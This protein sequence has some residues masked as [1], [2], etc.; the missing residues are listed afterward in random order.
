MDDV[1][2]TELFSAYLDGELTANEQVRVEQILAIS[3]EARQLLEELRA[4]G[5]TLQGVPQE[6][7]DEDLSLRV[8]EVA[9]QRMLLPDR[10]S[11]DA[12]NKPSAG[13]AA[14]FLNL[15][16]ADS[17]HGP[18]IPWREISWR[19]MFSKRALIWS[20]VV[21]ATAI[22]IS[23][24]SPPPPKPNHDLAKL[25]KEPAA[26]APAAFG[27]NKSSTSDGSWAAPA[28][29][30]RKPRTDDLLAKGE[31]RKA[32]DAEDR[33]AKTEVDGLRRN[34]KEK[35]AVPSGES[36]DES[37]AEAK[38]AQ[39]TV[40]SPP[41][42][43]MSKAPAKAEPLAMEAHGPA[44]AGKH[45]PKD[46][47]IADNSA[48][49]SKHGSKDANTADLGVAKS[50][51]TAQ[52]MNGTGFFSANGNS[53]S[54]GA[55][56]ASNFQGGQA[57]PNRFAGRKAPAATVVRINIS[58]LANQNRVF[59]N[60]L[61]YQGLG[62]DQNQQQAVSQFENGKRG[63]DRNLQQQL[64][65]GLM[66]KPA[67]TSKKQ[68]IQSNFAANSRPVTYE[69]DASPEQ[70]AILIKQLGE[71]PDSFSISEIEVAASASQTMNSSARNDKYQANKS[72]DGIGGGTLANRPDS[73][74]QAKSDAAG[75]ATV[76]RE[77]N[78]QSQAASPT[79]ATKQHVVFVLRVVDRVVPAAGRA[80][81]LP[82]ATAPAKQ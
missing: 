38:P 31:I 57:M 43:V 66:Q 81:Q 61:A 77:E 73:Q 51:E 13:R 12:G 32:A 21:V 54:T 45:V 63:G 25:D 27:E 70:L 9:E 59:E 16:E 37:F 75:G 44:S 69:F 55:V 4:L 42:V 80:S 40:P 34:E 24:T 74:R 47:D 48:L 62:I 1:P 7:L 39:A 8:M 65:E 78:A 5:S 36:S 82:A 41:A 79:T 46:A 26:T 17:T 2:D 49:R 72:N 6:K 53:T 50:S 11:N 14:E 35:K 19:G 10:L 68:E 22:I 58:A 64:P 3:P 67:E 33:K 76:A 18:G 23:F 15:P 56:A 52:L 28:G 60:L 30:P 20:S 71:R 29:S